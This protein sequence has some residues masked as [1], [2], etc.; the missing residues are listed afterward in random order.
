MDSHTCNTTA[1]SP[2][3]CLLDELGDGMFYHGSA[4]SMEEG[5]ALIWRSKRHPLGDLEWFLHEE[6]EVDVH[7]IVMGEGDSM[8]RRECA[9][10][11]M[12]A[13]T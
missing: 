7:L 11:E 2:G 13:L 5:G 8:W 9:V 3:V 6:V 10:M 1:C 4:I 12:E